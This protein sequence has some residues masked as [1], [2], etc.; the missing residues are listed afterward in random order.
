MLGLLSETS[1]S[2]LLYTT[3][4]VL[5]LT[6]HGVAAFCF[7]FSCKLFLSRQTQRPDWRFDG[8]IFLLCYFIPVF[9]I[10]IG[11]MIT[12]L[13]LRTTN[14]KFA[15]IIHNTINLNEAKPTQPKYG[16]G[17]ALIHLFQQD[18]TASERTDAL[19]MLGQRQLSTVNQ[20]MHQLLLDNQD[21]M[22]LLAFNILDQQQNLITEDVKKLLNLLKTMQ[23]WSEAHAR[24][25]KNL[26][27]LYWEMVYRQLVVHELEESMLN[28]AKIYAVS[29]CNMLKDDP[30]L[31]V[32]IGK[33]YLK[34][35]KYSDAESAFQQAFSCK[36]AVAQALPYL[37][38]IKYNLHDYLGVYQC[39]RES[40]TLLDIARVAPVK[41]FWEKND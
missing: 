20:L 32:L 31:W 21:E 22:R 18:K 37:A 1:A 24:V 33:I 3:Q 15:Y 14:K 5:M 17:G 8:T 40:D 36:I 11:F 25:E 2:F 26:A 23:P 28:Q 4:I 12:L 7:M 29:A 13:R 19:F 30:S 16:A 39:L 41:R 10:F 35:N 34:M 27:I 9:G 6:V 38:E